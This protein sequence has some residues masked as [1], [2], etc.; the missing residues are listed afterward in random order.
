MSIVE[1]E[2]SAG[3]WSAL[4]VFTIAV[5]GS[6]V[7]SAR[8]SGWMDFGL[9]GLLPDA[10]LFPLIALLLNRCGFGH[11][12]AMVTALVMVVGFLSFWMLCVIYAV[13]ETWWAAVPATF[14]GAAILFELTKRYMRNR[15]Q[16]QASAVVMPSDVNASV[17]GRR[18]KRK[19]RSAY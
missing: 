1:G 19:S 16:A 12:A 2:L 4:T 5:L 14:V 6:W 18:S 8:H 7:L 15:E 9:L 3:R 11:R 17:G 10:I 13:T